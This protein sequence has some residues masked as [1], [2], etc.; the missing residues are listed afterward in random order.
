MDDRS[1]TDL[2]KCPT[3][4]HSQIYPQCGFVGCVDLRIWA[5]AHGYKFRFEEGYKA[6]NSMHIRGDGRWY[7]EVLCQN[8]LIY[9]YGGTT[10]LAY[11]KGGIAKRVAELGQDV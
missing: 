1:L 5:K 3:G 10:I 8:G 6:E 7:V 4:E 9:P 11:A 2:G